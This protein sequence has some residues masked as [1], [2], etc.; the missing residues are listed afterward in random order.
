[1][2]SARRLIAVVS[3][4][5]GLT[6]CQRSPAALSQA[7]KDAVRAQIEK[8]R[9][10]SI[11]ADWTTWGSTL[12][13][14]VIISPAHMAPLMGRDAAVAWAKAFPKISNLSVLVDEISGRGDVAYDRGSYVLD[15]VLPD[16]RTA[17][18]HGTFLE[19]HRRQADGSWP[20]ARLSFH[21]TDPLPAPTP[22][23]AA[24]A[25]KPTKKS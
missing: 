14:D 18:E 11:A 23:P 15:M 20:Y 9:K 19:V 16:G 2:F 3:I 13:S 8:Y 17:S 10:A 1:M 12:M 25:A 7:D 5:A 4:V 24:P 22:V 6:A 21:S